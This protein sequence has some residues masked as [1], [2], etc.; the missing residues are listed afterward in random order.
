MPSRDLR[1]CLLSRPCED[2]ARDRTGVLSAGW[3]WEKTR[4][5]EPSLSP[6]YTAQPAAAFRTASSRTGRHQEE[7]P[8]DRISFGQIKPPAWRNLVCQF[9]WNTVLLRGVCRQKRPMH[10]IPLTIRCTLAT[11][12]IVSVLICCCQGG[13]LGKAFTRLVETGSAFAQNGAMGCCAAD[14]ADTQSA[15]DDDG[16]SCDCRAHTKAKSMPDAKLT[17]SFAGAEPVVTMTTVRVVPIAPAVVR[18]VASGDRVLSPPPTTLL[19]QQC[20]LIV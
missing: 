3:D 10:S 15:P 5:L 18:V 12:L 11:G 8:Y 4:S 9:S 7:H 6:S 1:R 17:V 13:S 2:H 14:D 20:A 19:R 16:R